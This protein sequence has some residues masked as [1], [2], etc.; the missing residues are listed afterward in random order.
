[1]LRDFVA[2]WLSKLSDHVLLSHNVHFF[3]IGES[4][5]ESELRD[6]MESMTN[7]T[8]APYA[9]E[10]EVM[11]RVTAAAKTAAD[12]DAL[13]K[14]VIEQLQTRYAKI[15]YGIDVGDLQ[16]AA[17]QALKQ[18]GLKVAIAESCTGGLI[19]E[20]LTRVPGSSEVFGCGVVSY[21][22]ETKQKLLGVSAQTLAQYGAVSA[23][24]ARE[25]AQGVRRVSG[26][27]IGISVTGIAG[28]DGGTPEKPVGLVYIGVNSEWHREAKGLHLSRGHK[29]ERELNRW[30]AASHALSMLLRTAQLHK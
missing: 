14:P 19:A 18:R 17:F 16:T 15:I 21:S 4:T 27:D 6:E 7:P 1:M 23:Q 10:G 11:L 30:L 22:N 9:K 20:R 2:P 29:D 12:A 25:M 26:A 5:L 24:T 28:P 13:M 3:G 8:L